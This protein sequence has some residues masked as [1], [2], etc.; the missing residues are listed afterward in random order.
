M[1]RRLPSTKA[2]TVAPATVPAPRSRIAPALPRSTKAGT[3]APATA[4]VLG[5]D[6]LDAWPRSTKA[7]TVAP[8]TVVRTHSQHPER[9]IRSTKAGTVAP[10]TDAAVRV[11]ACRDLLSLN[12]GR[13]RSPGDSRADEQ[14]AP[15]ADEQRSTKAGTVAPATAPIPRSRR[16]TGCALNEGR[17]RSPGDRRGRRPGRSAGSIPLNEGRDRSPGDR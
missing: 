4:R 8:A 13:D 2:G 17:D 9:A 1:I 3:V 11:D 15:G 16:S 6:K 12:E 14:V 10:A 7:G 5:G